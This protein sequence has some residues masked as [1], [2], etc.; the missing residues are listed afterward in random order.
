VEKVLGGDWGGVRYEGNLKRDKETGTVRFQETEA[1]QEGPSRL[2]IRGWS[3][4]PFSPAGRSEREKGSQAKRRKTTVAVEK[5]KEGRLRRR[6]ANATGG[7][8]EGKPWVSEK[9][10]SMVLD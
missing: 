10:K 9:E 3:V 8:N 2:R 4:V 6:K 1:R 5:K 7:R